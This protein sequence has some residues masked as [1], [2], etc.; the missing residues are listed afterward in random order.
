MKVVIL[1]GGF[2]SRIS[3]ETEYIPKPMI[4]LGGIPMIE[5]IIREYSYYGF[6]EFIICA[7]YKQQ[8]IKEYFA[9]YYLNHSNITFDMGNNKVTVHECNT[10]PWKITVVDTGLNTMTGGRIKRIKEYIDEDTFLLTYGD[11]LCDVNIKE[12]I[13]FHKKN[14]KLA[15]ITAIQ[16]IEKFG[17]LGIE[18]N[19]V[20]N[21]KEK[22]DNA[23]GWVNG[24]YMVLNTKVLDYIDGDDTA[25]EKKPLE[26]LAKEGNLIAYKYEGFWQCMDTLKDKKILESMIKDGNT[27]WIKR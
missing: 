3:E 20:Y 5:H 23:G 12:V 19:K 11:G 25:F 4:E 14:K 6:N 10:E 18:G 21:F 16:P 13:K 22:P 26:T 2:G 8:V 17:V 7:G 9:N 15:T 1:A 24:G 27:P